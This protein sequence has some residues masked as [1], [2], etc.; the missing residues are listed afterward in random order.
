MFS[1]EEYYK[2]LYFWGKF[3]RDPHVRYSGGELVRLKEDLD[4]IS[5]FELCKIVK[6]WLGFNTM[7]LIYFHIP[8]SRT[9]QDNL[10]VV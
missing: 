7:Q 2:N 5:Y 6:N 9:L 3:A 8:D 10:R 4:T 1:E